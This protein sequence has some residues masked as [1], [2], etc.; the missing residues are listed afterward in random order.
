MGM[1]MYMSFYQTN[2]L[3][4]LFKGLKSTTTMQYL[5]LLLLLFM[6]TILLEAFSFHRYIL[7]YKFKL[8]SPDQSQLMLRVQM[9]LSYLV[10]LVLA[11]GLMLAVMSFNGLVVVT[12]AIAHGISHFI[13]A[14]LKY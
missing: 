7:A 2:K 5:G 8:N 1:G 9:F 6:V 13:F 10:S 14:R 12:I 3:T 11:Y 4:L